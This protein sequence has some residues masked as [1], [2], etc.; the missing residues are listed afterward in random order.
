VLPLA[1]GPLLALV[2]DEAD[3][4]L[5][6]PQAASSNDATMTHAPTP[7]MGAA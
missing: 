1:A 7:R 2:V 6:E 5:E 4:P 3:L